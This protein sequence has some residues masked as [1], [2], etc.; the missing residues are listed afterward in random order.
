MKTS[1]KIAHKYQLGTIL[2]CFDK[3]FLSFMCTAIRVETSPNGEGLI[4]YYSG[5][6]KHSWRTFSEGEVFESPQ[7][8][9]AALIQ[10]EQK[11][12]EMRCERIESL[13]QSFLNNEA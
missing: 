9:S 12:F 13:L 4:Y 3:E 11:T 5:L 6:I 10:K 1:P 7:E 2:Y 8:L